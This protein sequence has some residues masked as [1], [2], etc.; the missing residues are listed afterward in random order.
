MK[1]FKKAA[2]DFVVKYGTVI[3]SCAFAFVVFAANS[4]CTLPF[5][6]PEEPKNLD[7]FKM[8]K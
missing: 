2:V 8:F 3:A 1:K 4:A 6:E 7:K 5:Y